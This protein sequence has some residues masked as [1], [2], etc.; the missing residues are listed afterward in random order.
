VQARIPN[1]EVSGVSASGFEDLLKPF[2]L[3]Y[4]VVVPGYA[5][6]TGQRMF[7]QPGYFTKGDAPWFT[8]PTRTYDICFD[9]ATLQEDEVTI[10]VPDNYSVEADSMPQPRSLQRGEMGQYTVSVDFKPQTGTITYKRTFEL[11]LLR[12][13]AT[14]YDNL[15]KL[16]DFL[17]A[18]D[19]HVLMLRKVN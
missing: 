15:K 5:E 13:P 3:T 10:R 18:Q 2:V 19:T 11:S 16:F 9:Y 8:A 4:K 12:V 17:H 14:A 7:V 1:A 6:Q